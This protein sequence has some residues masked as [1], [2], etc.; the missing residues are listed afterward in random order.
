MRTQNMHGCSVFM[1]PGKGL[2]NASKLEQ[3]VSLDVFKSKLT[4]SEVDL[5]VCAV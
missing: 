4:I 3:R 2:E 1:E 5:T